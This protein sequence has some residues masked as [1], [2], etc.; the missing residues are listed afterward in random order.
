MTDP[1]LVLSKLQKSGFYPLH[2]EFCGCIWVNTTLTSVA[3]ETLA[4]HIDFQ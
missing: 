3:Y 2:C 1:K 4:K